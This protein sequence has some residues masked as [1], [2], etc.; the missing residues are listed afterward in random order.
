MLIMKLFCCLSCEQPSLGFGRH[1]P[2]AFV[3]QAL[4]WVLHVKPMSYSKEGGDVN[5]NLV[6]LQILMTQSLQI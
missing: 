2:V 5:E 1:D 3:Q 4:E 6:Y